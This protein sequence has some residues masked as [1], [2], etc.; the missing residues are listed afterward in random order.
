MVTVS[1]TGPA[2]ETANL[3]ASGQ[4]VRSTTVAPD[5]TFS[6]AVTVTSTSDVSVTFSGEAPTACVTPS[7]ASVVPVIV[8]G[9]RVQAKSALAFTGSPNAPSYL[10]IGLAALVG[11]LVLVVGAR[12]ASNIERRTH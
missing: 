5:G 10:F 2:G 11:G 3:F 4:K 12:R 1:G 7:G 8:A 9:E 6:L